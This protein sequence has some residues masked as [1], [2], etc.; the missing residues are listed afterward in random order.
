[1]IRNLKDFI[2]YVSDNKITIIIDEI[3]SLDLGR[4]TFEINNHILAIKKVEMP[5]V[6]HQMIEG[7]INIDGIPETDRKKI[8][9]TGEINIGTI[10][11]DSKLTSAFT[12][13]RN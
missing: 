11:K 12:I 9:S 13:F 1:M 8:S 4:A 5:N 10:S 6:N 3:P 7:T 2:L